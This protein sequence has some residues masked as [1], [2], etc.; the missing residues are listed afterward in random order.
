MEQLEIIEAY[1]Y[2][3]LGLELQSSV[4]VKHRV[5]TKRILLLFILPVWL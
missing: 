1:L 5:H 2:R 4:R 3:I